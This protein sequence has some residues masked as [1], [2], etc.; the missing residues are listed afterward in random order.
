MLVVKGSNFQ[1]LQTDLLTLKARVGLW[2][3]RI[4]H[5]ETFLVVFDGSALQEVI[6][7]TDF[8]NLEFLPYC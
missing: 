2:R 3:G 6:S 8:K 5:Y 7:K 1:E 4:A